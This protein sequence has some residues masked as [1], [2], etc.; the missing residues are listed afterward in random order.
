MRSRSVTDVR[1]PMTIPI[2]PIAA[3]RLWLR[4]ALA[5][6]LFLG[7]CAATSDPAPVRPRPLAVAAGDPGRALREEVLRIRLPDAPGIELE[8]TLYR[9]P[10]DGPFPLV[11]INHG[12]AA[13]DP[14]LQQRSRFIWAARAFVARGYAVALPMRQG[15]AGSSGRYPN[16]G[17]DI[18]AN[19]RISAQDVSATISYF[20]HRADIDTRR[21]VL[22]GQSAGGLVALAAA[23]QKLPQVAGVVNFAGGLRQ[24]RCPDW[25]AVLADTAA[26]YGR[27]THVPTLWFYGDNDATFAA[28]VWHEMHARYVAAGGDAQLVAYGRFGK[29]AHALFGA[30][31]GVPVWEPELARFFTTKLG[32][33][34]ASRSEWASD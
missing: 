1:I 23:S 24:D 21:V 12:K 8:T 3:Q 13:G 7:G 33:P 25:P 14:R 27:T 19:G 18:A 20:A 34:F 11:I 29:D 15:F 30:R 6:A 4:L 31:S 10:G 28:P 16:A 17:C 26:D 22:V 2:D 5:A 9:P 32:L